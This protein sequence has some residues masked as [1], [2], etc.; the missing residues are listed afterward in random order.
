MAHDVTTTTR[1]TTQLLHLYPKWRKATKKVHFPKTTFYRTSPEYIMIALSTKIYISSCHLPHAMLSHALLFPFT[2][3]SVSLSPKKKIIFQ[4]LYPLSK[5]KMELFS[6]HVISYTLNENENPA[7]PYKNMHVHIMLVLSR[8]PIM[9][10]KCC[11]YCC[12]VQHT[13]S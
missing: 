9:L 4:P 8:V 11:C 10:L 12:Y 3:T 6:T 1:F 2:L 5:S 7:L 13:A